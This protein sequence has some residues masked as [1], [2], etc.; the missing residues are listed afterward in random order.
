MQ[1]INNTTATT[2][3]FSEV[4]NG[5][6]F[7]HESV[8]YMRIED[9][10]NGNNVVEIANGIQQSMDDTSVVVIPTALLTLTD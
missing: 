3:E 6:V 4:E 8:V 10:G 9:S 5:Q 7:I 1:I 2:S